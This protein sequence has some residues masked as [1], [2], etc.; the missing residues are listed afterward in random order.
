MRFVL[1]LLQKPLITPVALVLAILLALAFPRQASSEYL[2]G[3][4]IAE[5]PEE[6]MSVIKADYEAMEIAYSNWL[7]EQEK[8]KLITKAKKLIGT[9]QGQCVVADRKFLELTPDQI[10][11]IAR[12][13][14]VDS[15]EP[16]IGAIV[17]LKES[18]AGH[19]AVVLDVTPTQIYIY[20][21]N[22]AAYERASMRWVDR[23]YNL[24]LGY[25]K[26]NE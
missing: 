25:K 20:E 12:N 1:K 7:K 22:Y 17:K 19:V 18:R 11:G 21:S 8:E 26:F 16:E 4:I 2:Q 6:E 23:N 5:H 10:S 15:Q 14:V 9:R 24:I 3:G 13:F